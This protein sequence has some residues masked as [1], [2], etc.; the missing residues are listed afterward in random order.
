MFLIHTV[1]LILMPKSQPCQD[2]DVRAKSG[3]CTK[4][5]VEVAWKRLVTVVTACDFKER[6]GWPAPW[7]D[8]AP[9]SPSNG[10]GIRCGLFG[11]SDCQS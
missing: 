7:A 2:S 8:A 3:P 10:N 1:P 4:R 11:L 5:C 6:S 9:P